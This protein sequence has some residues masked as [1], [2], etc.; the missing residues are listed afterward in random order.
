MDEL[1]YISPVQNWASFRNPANLVNVLDYYFNID[2]IDQQLEA[3]R[4]GLA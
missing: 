3:V 1:R 2:E 4:L